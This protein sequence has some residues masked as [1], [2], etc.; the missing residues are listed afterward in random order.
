MRPHSVDEQQPQF[1]STKLIIESLSANA[2]KRLELYTHDK[3]QGL[4]GIFGEIN[5]DSND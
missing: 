3:D 2:D 4:N 1:V 5:C